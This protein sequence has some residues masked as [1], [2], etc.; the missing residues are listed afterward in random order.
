MSRPVRTAAMAAAAALALPAVAEGFIHKPFQ[1]PSKRIMCAYIGETTR[2]AEI[3]CDLHFLNDVAYVVGPKGKGRRIH[4]TDAVGDPKAKVL[5][6]GRSVSYGRYTCT[7]R[8]S[9]LTCRNR[10]TG[11]GFT[12]SRERRRVF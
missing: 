2:T 10:G 12:V 8:T 4:V 3:R 11:H 1:T 9:G 6:Y 7:S 5:A